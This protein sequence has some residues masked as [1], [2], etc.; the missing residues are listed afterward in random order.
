MARKQRT[1]PRLTTV[2]LVR[3]GQT[4]TTGSTL[5]GRAPGLHLADAGVEEAGRAAER[6][7]ELSNVAAVYSSPLER[8]RQTAG[9]IAAALGTRAAVVKGLVEC[10]FGDWTGR[11]LKQLVK[12]PEWKTVQQAPSTF[13]FPNGESFS[14]MQH[15]MVTTIDDLRARHVGGTIVCVSHADP[16]KALVAHAV[17]THLDLFQRIVISTCSITALVWG[18]GAPLALT[19]NSTGGSLAELQPS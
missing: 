1:S 5:P 14:E 9:P 11:E 4:P 16:I 17:G 12:L 8:A 3:H 2:L 7:A 19:V 6:I 10:D 15:R 18:N 13:R